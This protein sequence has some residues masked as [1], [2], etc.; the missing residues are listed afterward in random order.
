MTHKVYLQPEHQTISLPEAYLDHQTIY[1]SHNHTYIE[2]QSKPCFR[3]VT[4]NP[5]YLVILFARLPCLPDSPDYLV[6]LFTR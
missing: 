2:G 1:Q 3:L 5:D 6:T 4:C